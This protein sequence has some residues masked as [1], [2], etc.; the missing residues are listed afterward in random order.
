MEYILI[1][2]H[3]NIDFHDAYINSV[4]LQG[5]NMIW[6]LAALQTQ[7]I[8]HDVCDDNCYI[9]NAVMILEEAHIESI[10][11]SGYKHYENGVL[12]ASKESVFAPPNKFDTLL[13]DISYKNYSYIFGIKELSPTDK[14][15]Y[16]ISIMTKYEI[17]ITF[18][19][20]FIKWS[21]FGG[22]EWYRSKMW[23]NEHPN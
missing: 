4:Y 22:V 15:Q 9:K 8:I 14:K 2:E 3:S 17:T 10:F 5:N 1:N 7:N 19:K 11:I 23:T 16:K 13:K 20:S 6:E 21:E 18:E 12:K